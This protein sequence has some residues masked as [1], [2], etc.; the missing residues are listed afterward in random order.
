MMSE[1]DAAVTCMPSQ[2]VLERFALA[3]ARLQWRVF[4]WYPSAVCYQQLCRPHQRRVIYTVLCA[5]AR[6][7]FDNEQDAY[8][9]CELWTIIRSFLKITDLG[10]GRLDEC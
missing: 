9:P 2:A 8:A 1:V 5:E 6:L 3:K 10:M 7:S 4:R